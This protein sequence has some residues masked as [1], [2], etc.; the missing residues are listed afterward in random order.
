MNTFIPACAHVLSEHKGT[1]ESK[2][3]FVKVFKVLCAGVLSNGKEE[4]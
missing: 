1:E 2:K 3:E 4:K